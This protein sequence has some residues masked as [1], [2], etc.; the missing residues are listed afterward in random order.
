MKQFTSEEFTKTF[1]AFASERYPTSD[2]AMR[3]LAEYDFIAMNFDDINTM[4][5]KIAMLTMFRNVVKEVDPLRIFQSTQ[6]RDEIFNAFIEALEE[7]EEQLEILE[8]EEEEEEF[9]YLET[10]EKEVV[11]GPVEEVKEEKSF[12]ELTEEEMKEQWWKDEELF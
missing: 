4:K 10:E 12:W 3:I 6:H 9:E 2:G 7:L 1:M 8:E 11:E 5:M